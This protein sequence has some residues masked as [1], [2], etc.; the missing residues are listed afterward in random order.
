VA[1]PVALRSLAT[2]PAADARD[3]HPKAKAKANA[4]ALRI[5]CGKQFKLTE[6]SRQQTVQD[7]GYAGSGTRRVVLVA[8]IDRR[9]A[10][11]KT[12]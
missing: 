12:G 3:G 6:N 8:V 1:T 5:A 7:N 11:W 9:G 10:I 2:M 4:R